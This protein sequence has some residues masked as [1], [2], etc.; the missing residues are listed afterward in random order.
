M[1]LSEVHDD[2]NQH[3]EGFLLVGLQDIEEVVVLEETHGPVGNLQMDAA[4]A[5]DDSLEKLGNEVLDLVHLADFE[6]LLKF[7]QE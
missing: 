7:G 1:V 2:W 4:N 5:L 3:G 6:D